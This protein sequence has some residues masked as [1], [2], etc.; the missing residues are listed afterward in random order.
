MSSVNIST[1][2]VVYKD[3]SAPKS[4]TISCSARYRLLDPPATSSQEAAETELL[5]LLL[6]RV[7]SPVEAPP[8]EGAE[9]GRAEAEEYASSSLLIERSLACLRIPSG[10]DRVLLGNSE[11]STLDT[12][13]GLVE[14]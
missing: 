10:S 1:L 8:V 11:P 2:C 7:G 13:R 3:L 9:A 12:R 14:A 5:M 4:R 6:V